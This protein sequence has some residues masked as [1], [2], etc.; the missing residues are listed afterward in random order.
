MIIL[1]SSICGGN[2]ITGTDLAHQLL[3]T[4]VVYSVC[5]AWLKECAVELIKCIGRKSTFKAVDICCILT[6]HCFSVF[7]ALAF[8]E[9][10]L[11]FSLSVWVRFT[12]S[13]RSYIIF[14]SLE[15]FD[16][17]DWWQIRLVSCLLCLELVSVVWLRTP[18]S[19]FDYFFV[20]SFCFAVLL[21]SVVVW[22]YWPLCLCLTKLCSFLDSLT[23]A[24]K[25][26][27]LSISRSFIG[28]R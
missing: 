8:F 3:E 2:I 28:Y 14:I 10:S 23:K 7:R 19:F 15:F 1:I 13:G 11:T 21:R 12:C 6:W 25:L 18:L 17:G 4:W 26:A 24:Y 16:Y 9:S 20:A 5:I 27:L 22:Q